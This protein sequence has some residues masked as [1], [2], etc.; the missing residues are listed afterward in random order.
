MSRNQQ[1]DNVRA[2]PGKQA[3][4]IVEER[5]KIDELQAN[6]D[7]TKEALTEKTEEVADLV[8]DIR[9]TLDVIIEEGEEDEDGDEDYIPEEEE[10][11]EDED[12]GLIADDE[13]EENDD[14]TGKKRP[15]DWDE[16][17][18][19]ERKRAST[20]AREALDGFNAFKE[21][22][23]NRE[24]TEST[25]VKR[26]ETSI[27]EYDRRQS[28]ILKRRLLDNGIH[29]KFRTRKRGDREGKITRRDDTQEEGV[30]YNPHG[31]PE[32]DDVDVPEEE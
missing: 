32:D 6:I 2:R 19:G 3:D 11:E 1:E 14:Y 9:Q 7:E 8:G 21:T 12:E 24:L 20:I 5:E 30:S 28:Y 18:T 22:T 31:I 29:P 26:V 25:R 4:L 27:S 15:K 23:E 16:E 13:D 17:D 10:E